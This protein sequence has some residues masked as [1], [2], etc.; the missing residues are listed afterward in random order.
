[1]PLPVSQR[2]MLML[3]PSVVRIVVKVP[4]PCIASMAFLQMFS[5]THSKRYR[6][7]GATTGRSG[8]VV[9]KWTL[10]GLR[11]SI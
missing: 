5:I 1:M 9:T 11:F 4:L 8:S 10:R 3:L 7:T 6:L 2:S